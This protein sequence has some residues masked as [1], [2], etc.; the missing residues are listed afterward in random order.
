MLLRGWV[1]VWF[2][3][4]IP[5]SAQGSAGFEGS[6]DRKNTWTLLSDYSNTSNHVIAGAARQRELVTLGGGYTRR[7][8]RFWG[9]ELGYRIELRPVVFESDPVNVITTTY[10][11]G[12]LSGTVTS[13]QTTLGVCR[14]YTSTQTIQQPAPYPPESITTV[15]TCGRQWTFGQ[16]FAPFGVRYAFGYRH[17]VQPFVIGTLGY[18]YTSRPVPVSNAE[19]FNFV[20]DSGAGVEVFR[21]GRRS[22]SVEA[23]AHHFSNRDTA[24]ANPGTD[25]VVYGVSYSFGR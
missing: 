13:T 4:A 17:R 6:Y 9:T 22:L 21:S 5:C 16:A 8:V 15:A 1:L 18:M 24:Q 10:S 19:S 2:S 25:N 3:F 12:A 14:P 11:A 23:R 20:I 7:V